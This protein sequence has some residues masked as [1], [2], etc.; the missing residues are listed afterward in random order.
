MK[1][2]DNGQARIEVVKRCYT[3]ERTRLFMGAC[4]GTETTI[5]L[6]KDS[7]VKDFD[8]DVTK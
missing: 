2:I 3:E 6:P 8:I 7:I 4:Y 1:E 5:Y